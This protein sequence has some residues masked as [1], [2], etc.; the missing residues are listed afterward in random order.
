MNGSINHVTG[1]PAPLGVG[2]GVTIVTNL[3]VK[4]GQVY[5][6]KEK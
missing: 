4:A 3:D 6:D 2:G 5:K 1:A